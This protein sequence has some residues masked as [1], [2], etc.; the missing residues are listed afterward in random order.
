M[1]ESVT[2]ANQVES[3]EAIVAPCSSHCYGV[4]PYYQDDV[5]TIYHGDCLEVLPS[6][7]QADLYLLDLPYGIDLKEH[8]R[9]GYD[10][11]VK[12]D[13]SQDFG[14][15]VLTEVWD[16]PIVAF[17]SPMLPWAGKW[18][19]HLVWDKG[20]TVGGGGDIATCWK[21]SWELVQV[22]NTGKLNGK[23]DE[24]VMT[25]HVT[26]R[27]YALHPCQKPLGLLQYLICKTTKPGDV[28]VDLTCGSGSVLEAAK[29]SGRRAVGVET[30][31]KYC[32]IAAKR[33]SQGVLF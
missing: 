26:Q 30:E 20:P 16:R 12:G 6:L 17:A 31:E 23:R 32:A 3:N 27:D 22:R 28:V 11:K 24:A 21:L 1:S 19:Q 10:W 7:P 9:N 18:R 33:V 15:A 8:G 29:V 13:E 25:Y 4:K 14:H 2:N 5:C